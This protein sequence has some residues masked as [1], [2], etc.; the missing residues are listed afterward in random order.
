M[1][2]DCSCADKNRASNQTHKVRLINYCKISTLVVVI[3]IKARSAL[4]WCIYVIPPHDRPLVP[5]KYSRPEVTYPNT[6]TRG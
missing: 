4:A 2:F 6:H 3:S 5:A 1:I